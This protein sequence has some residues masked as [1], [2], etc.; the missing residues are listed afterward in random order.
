MKGRPLSTRAILPAAFAL[1]VLGGWY[2]IVLALETP[3]YLLPAP[4]EVLAAGRAEGAALAAAAITTGSA[5]LLGLILSAGAGFFLAVLLAASPGTHRTLY[6]YVL[7][8]QTV[9]VVILTPILVLWLGPGLPSVTAVTFLITFF[10]VTSNTLEGL[11]STPHSMIDLFR[12]YDAGRMQEMMRLRIPWALPH[13]LSGLR[14]AASLAPIGAIAGEFFAGSG[15]TGGG[16]LGYRVIVY[17]SR[18]ETAALFAAGLTACGLGFAFVGAVALL[19][20]FALRHW[21]ESAKP[22]D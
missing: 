6:P 15:G 9:P 14:I 2:G 7:L 12:V 19:A 5:A 3:A 17:F 8:L 1:V 16:G 21:H 4:H 10:P 18:H 20:R 11:R 22:R 13:Y